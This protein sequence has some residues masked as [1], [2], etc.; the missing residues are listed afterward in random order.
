[1]PTRLT[2]TDELEALRDADTL[3][4]L[5]PEAL[6]ASIKKLAED[7]LEYRAAIARVG[8]SILEGEFVLRNGSTH[9][10]YLDKGQSGHS[11]E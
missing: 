2:P 4:M 3:H 7:A 1:M 6:I 11:P 10:L 5:P 9:H 8:L